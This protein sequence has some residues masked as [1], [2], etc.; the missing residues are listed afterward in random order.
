M[1]KRRLVCLVLFQC[2]LGGTAFA[3]EACADLIKKPSGYAEPL[4]PIGDPPADPTPS[5][6]FYSNRE[7]GDMHG[8]ERLTMLLDVHGEHSFVGVWDVS[9]VFENHEQ[10]KGRVKAKRAECEAEILK[11]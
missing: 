10:L 4:E 1:I 2:A 5:A 3:V 9:A 8:V 7:A 11:P 6:R